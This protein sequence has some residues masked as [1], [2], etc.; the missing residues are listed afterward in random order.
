[1]K[2]RRWFG[3]DGKASRDVD[4]TD[5]GNPKAHPEVPHE[6]IWDWGKNPPRSK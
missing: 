3:P 1:M 5:H 2:T 6:H 4:Y